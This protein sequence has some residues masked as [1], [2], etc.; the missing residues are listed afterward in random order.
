MMGQR[1]VIAIGACVAAVFTVGT[2][3]AILL[4]S[5]QVDARLQDV[6]QTTC[7]FNA[8]L[9]K[10]F[11]VKVLNEAEA[12]GKGDTGALSV[13]LPKSP[14]H[15]N[16]KPIDVSKLVGPRGL[17]GAA[18]PEGPPGPVG[19]KG[20]QGDPGTAGLMGAIGATGPEGPAG[21]QGPPGVDGP[22]GD[23]GDPGVAGPQGPVGPAGPEGP[24]GPTGPQGAQG[25][26]GTATDPVAQARLD[27]ED[28]T[29]TTQDARIAALESEVAA[30][31]AAAVQS[32]PAP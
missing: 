3:G 1:K 8:T 24:A 7:H 11:R 28:A 15:P 18:G 17:P 26:P 32:P 4:E 14:K 5:H 19:P 20:P 22:K 27:A 21:P 23:K 30:L 25:A 31:Q 9:I 6:A 13:V 29:N 12:C 2:T 10:K 16:P